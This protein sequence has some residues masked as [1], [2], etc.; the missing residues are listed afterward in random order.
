MGGAAV[1]GAAV[2]GAAVDWQGK[3]EA[4]QLVTRKLGMQGAVGSKMQQQRSPEAAVGG[5]GGGAAVVPHTTVS[6]HT[7]PKPTHRSEG[8]AVQVG[9]SQ[10]FLSGDTQQQVSWARARGSRARSSSIFSVDSGEKRR[11]RKKS[12]ARKTAG[13]GR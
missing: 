13:K 8:K 9:S 1:G 12:G 7:P 6:R 11:E 5:G 3:P 10:G 2:G 4:V